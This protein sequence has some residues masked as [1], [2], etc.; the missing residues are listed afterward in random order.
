MRVLRRGSES[1]IA[2]AR[3]SRERDAVTDV[4]HAGDQLD[5]PFEAQAKANPTR[6]ESREFGA[7]VRVH[8]DAPLGGLR[9]ARFDLEVPIVDLIATRE[10]LWVLGRDGTGVARIVEVDPV[11]ERPAHLRE[12]S[13]DLP[14]RA[15]LEPIE[16]QP[17][18]LINLP[19]GCAF[20]PRCDLFEKGLC[21]KPGAVPP[22]ETGP[23]HTARCYRTEFSLDDPV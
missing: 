1:K 9:R 22:I 20:G 3:R 17:P 6:G 18:D 13:L 12:V 23:E 15:R 16:G 10:G 4:G 14:R 5:H 7:P 8:R 21:D 2:V 11:E 19:Q